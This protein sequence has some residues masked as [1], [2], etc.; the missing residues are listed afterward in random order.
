M[1]NGKAE[2][3]GLV[4]T[5]DAIENSGSGLGMVSLG[6]TCGIGTRRVETR[7]SVDRE[8]A[9]TAHA[10]LSLGVVDVVAMSAGDESGLREIVADDDS[11]RLG[12]VVPPE[13]V[14]EGGG[15]VEIVAIEKT[16]DVGGD[17]ATI[18]GHRP[19]AEEGDGGDNVGTRSPE[20]GKH[21][22]R[23]EAGD[24]DPGDAL[25]DG[26]DTRGVE[27]QF[28]GDFGQRSHPG[29]LADLGNDY[30]TVELSAK[31]VELTRN[32]H[33][34]SDRPEGVRGSEEN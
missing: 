29:R 34:F 20:V 24:A 33:A 32:K 14:E 17:G 21:S 1:G 3:L 19:C 30:N 10:E 6:K 13:G 16:A 31:S 28:A 4:G 25:G 2:W 9:E 8:I 26:I 22:G 27:K 7:H 15:G 12:D 11:S 5:E 18:V 23:E